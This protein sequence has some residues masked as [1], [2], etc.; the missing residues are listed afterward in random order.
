MD[1][2]FNTPE[3]MAVLAGVARELNI[4]KAAGDAARI[5]GLARSLR[6]MGKVLGIL[7]QSPDTY[8]K[9]AARAGNAALE[10]ADAGAVPAAYTDA[11]IEALIAERRA[12]RAAKD[13]RASD[14][15]RDRLSAAGIVLEDKPGGVTEWRR[16]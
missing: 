12:A 5:A 7:Q 10:G 16:A 6:G 4:A 8:L 13:F 15:I 14:R 9:R 2:D 3:A 1:D 11:E